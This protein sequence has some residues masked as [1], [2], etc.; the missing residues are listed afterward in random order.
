MR[1][2]VYIIIY[3]FIIALLSGCNDNGKV[4]DKTNILLENKNENDDKKEMEEMVISWYQNNHYMYDWSDEEQYSCL[5]DET[6]VIYGEECYLAILYYKGKSIMFFAANKET[7][8]IFCNYADDIFIP[9]NRV[10]ILDSSQNEKKA[11]NIM[12]KRFNKEK[13]KYMAYCDTI[14][15]ENIRYFVYGEFKSSQLKAIFLI[16]IETEEIYKWDLSADKL[17]EIKKK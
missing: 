10:K 14:E 4:A 7:G 6:A 11:T 3:A 2:V 5:C 17:I 1:R 8:K 12:K 16:K 15:R 13:V 9:L